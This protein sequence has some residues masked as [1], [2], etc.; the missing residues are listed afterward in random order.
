M[1]PLSF[2]SPDVGQIEAF[3]STLYSKLRIGAT[4]ACTRAQ[5]TRR[6]MA[7]GIGF[8]DLDYSFDIGYAGE[9]PDLVII[10]DV[11]S[12]TIRRVGEGYD[13]TF[14]PGDQFLISRPGLPYSGVA[15]S[16]RLQFT[17]L[18]P[19]LLSR[20]AA[21][22]T[23]LAH[24]VRMLDHRPVSRKAAL[25]L[26]RCLAHLRNSVLTVP[27]ALREPLVVSTASQYL[28]ANVLQTFPNTALTEPTPQDHLDAHPASVR[29]AIA[30]MDANVSTDIDLTDIAGAAYVSP[31]A[32]QY[33]FR[34]HLGM[35]PM[36]YLRRARLDAAHHALQ[37]ADPSCGATV[38]AIAARW[39][40]AHPSR[41]ATIYRQTYGQSPSTA[42]HA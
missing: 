1:E 38:T 41:F 26:Q 11:L 30:F 9:P 33:A 21:T 40:F 27:E 34:R 7:P 32:L 39:G 12:N 3:V 8:D 25:R 22:R 36:A 42:L 23:D 4:G 19:A 29:R 31:R 14:G 37:A 28:A 6:V 35:T 17:V 5:I 20:V 18:D 2:D 10:C 15:H 16:S 24:P 13:E